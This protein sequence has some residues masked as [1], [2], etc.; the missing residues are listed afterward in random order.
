MEERIV[1][2]LDQEEEI[3]DNSLRP[4]RLENFVGQKKVKENI[5]IFLSRQ[6]KTGAKHLTTYFFTD[7]P[8]WERQHWPIL[9]QTN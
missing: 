9:F 5:G 7:H 4:K 1:S 3:F 8:V 6:Q 2:P